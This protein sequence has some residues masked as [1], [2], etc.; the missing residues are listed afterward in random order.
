MT[1]KR[2][3]SWITGATAVMIT[4]YTLYKVFSGQPT[5]FNEILAIGSTL[6]LFFSAVTWGR[7]G[8]D[9]GVRQDEELGKRISEKS[10]MIGYYILL[11]L[12]F[13]ACV[14]EQWFYGTQSPFLLILLVIGLFLHPMIEFVQVRKYR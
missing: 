14:S 1:T 6:M 11:A 9:N 2:I 10:G 7:K 12:L 5:G 4:S 8:E 3:L 13:L